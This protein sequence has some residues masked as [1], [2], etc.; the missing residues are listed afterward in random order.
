VG[1]GEPSLE[2]ELIKNTV[3][4]CRLKFPDISFSI[5]T[6]GVFNDG[7]LIFLLDN[8]FDVIFSLDGPYSLVSS[9]QDGIYSELIHKKVEDNIVK[10]AS[11]SKL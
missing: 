5:Q 1:G 11:N 9:F 3:H 10:Y 4:Y 8:N 2:S 7:F 6:N